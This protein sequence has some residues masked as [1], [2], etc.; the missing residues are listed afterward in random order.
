MCSEHIE[1]NSSFSS[2][3]PISYIQSTRLFSM[4]GTI[5]WVNNSEAKDPATGTAPSPVFTSE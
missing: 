5:I 2:L 4:G 1:F 3:F